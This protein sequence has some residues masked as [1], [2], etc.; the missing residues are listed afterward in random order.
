MSI[1]VRHD[2]A[3]ALEA[4]VAVTQYVSAVEVGDHDADELMSLLSRAGEALEA[5]VHALRKTLG[6]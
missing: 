1:K 4:H 6:R 3:N 5:E 2:P